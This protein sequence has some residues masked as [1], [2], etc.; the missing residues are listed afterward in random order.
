[1]ALVTLASY[2]IATCSPIAVKT[3]SSPMYLPCEIQEVDEAFCLFICLLLMLMY[4]RRPKIVEPR[5]G[6]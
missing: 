1:M 5:G 2:V 6:G 3:V 4:P